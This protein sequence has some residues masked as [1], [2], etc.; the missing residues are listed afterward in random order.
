MIRMEDLDR[1]RVRPGAADAI[2]RDLAWLGLDWDEGPDLGGPHAPYAQ[3]ERL[4]A[5]DAA[6]ERLRA[7]DRV[8]PCFC[9]RRD[10]AAAASAPQAPGDE[11]R[12]PGTCRALDPVEVARRLAKATPH[13]WRCRVDDGDEP[14][15]L[16]RIRGPW[17]VDGGASTGD[18]V[19]RRA[20]RVPAYQ[21]AVVVDDA[22][23]RINEVVRGD[24]LLPSTSR[25]LLLYSALGLEAP[26]FAHV[27]LLLGPDGVR[28]SKRHAGT[29]IREIREKGFR[30]E[31][32]IGR[33]AHALG[34]EIGAREIRA[35]DLLSGFSLQRVRGAPEGIQ[36][37][38]L[39]WSPGAS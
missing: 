29:T 28:L 13:A 39:T 5:Y 20:D 36:V 27:P 33:I 9:S 19:V 4:E 32:V 31:A 12:Y 7:Q 37:D 8:Y 24:D 3:W 1:P 30:A 2:L 34:L 11:V 10:I 15:F 22:A 21:L 6:F 26:A 35:S 14:G 18:F 16:D 23:M 25:Q 17:S 38:P